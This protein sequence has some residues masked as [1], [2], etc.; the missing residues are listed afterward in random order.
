MKAER[1][2]KQCIEAISI[3][4]KDNPNEIPSK[5]SRNFNQSTVEISDEPVTVNVIADR[6]NCVLLEN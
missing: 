3:Y 4:L 1:Y 6:I 2:G 5:L